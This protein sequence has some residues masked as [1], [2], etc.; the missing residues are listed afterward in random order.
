MAAIFFHDVQKAAL[1]EYPGSEEHH[2]RLAKR[3]L[4]GMDEVCGSNVWNV[5]TE[6]SPG[7]LALDRIL[8]SIGIDRHIGLDAAQW[9]A[10]RA[11]IDE[12][13]VNDR[14]KI[15]HG[16]GNRVSRDALLERARRLLALFDHLTDA[17]LDAATRRDYAAVSQH[18]DSISRDGP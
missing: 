12:Q 8:L 13:I 17:I 7:T 18:A 5:D 15:A 16:E 14:H 6:A 3:I 9:A 2:V 10:T 1:A 11:F 4:R